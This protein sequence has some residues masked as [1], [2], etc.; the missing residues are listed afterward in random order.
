MVAAANGSISLYSTVGAQSLA[1]GKPHVYV[2]D[3]YHNLFTRLGLIPTAQTA[4]ELVQLLN[5]TLRA[6]GYAIGGDA[7][8][9]AGVPVNGTAN[10]IARLRALLSK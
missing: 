10:Q 9:A 1:I 7:M 6:E 8:A 4:A 5:V 2:T 3:D